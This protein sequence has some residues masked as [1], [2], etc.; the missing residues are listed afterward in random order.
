MISD[1]FPLSIYTQS[2]NTRRTQSMKIDYRKTNQSIETNRCQLVNWYQLVSVNRLSIDSHIKLSANY[3]DFHLLAILIGYWLLFDENRW[4]VTE[5]CFID[6]LLISNINQLINCYRLI[7]IGIDF[8]RL[9]NSSIACIL[10]LVCISGQVKHWILSMKVD[11]R[12]TWL[13]K[14]LAKTTYNLTKVLNLCFIWPPACINLWLL[15]WTCGDVDWAQTC[16]QV[17][18]WPPTASQHKLI[19]C[20]ASVFWKRGFQMTGA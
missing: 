18:V 2:C 4:K 20:N 11:K 7:S 5:S 9:T 15:V 6:C 17:T 10:A 1:N 8:D 12:S 16:T 13:N 19:V 3:M 14:T